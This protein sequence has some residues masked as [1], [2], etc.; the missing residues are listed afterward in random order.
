MTRWQDQFRRFFSVGVLGFALDGC[1]LWL[2]VAQGLDAVAARVV[3][4]T[5]AVTL[6]W[7]LNRRWSFAQAR[8][9]NKVFQYVRYILV[10][11]IGAGLNLSTYTA[12]LSLW[13]E[14]LVFLFLPLCVG[15]IV[16]LA[17]NFCCSRWWVFRIPESEAGAER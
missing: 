2:L 11:L 3:S 10:Q 15:G 12:M 13:P 4:L 17:F 14:L 5:S 6:T 1:L 8:H 9:Q 16:G 7:W